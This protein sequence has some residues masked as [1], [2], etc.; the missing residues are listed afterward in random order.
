MLAMQAEVIFIFHNKGL[1][2]Y[3]FSR[4]AYVL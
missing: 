2:R 4:A 3:Y 1:T